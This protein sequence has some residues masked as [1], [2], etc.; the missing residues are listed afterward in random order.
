MHFD[1]TNTNT[2]KDSGACIQLQNIIG[3]P[4]LWVACRKHIG[5]I[6]VG[7]AF[8]ILKVEVN[9]SPDVLVFKRFREDF[10]KIALGTALKKLF[11]INS[12]KPEHQKFFTTQKDIVISTLKEAQKKGAYLRSDYKEL[13]YLV[14][15]Y[16]GEI[17]KYEIHKPGAT[18]RARWLM[19]LLHSI[20][21]VILE[22]NLLAST[23]RK[24]QLKLINRFVLFFVFC[25]VPWW[26]TCPIGTA[27][28]RNDIAFYK[29]VCNYEKIDEDISK[30]LQES[31][32]FHQWCIIPETI[33]LAPFDEGLDRCEKD[34]LAK[35]I[36]SYPQEESKTMHGNGY[37]K[38]RFQKMLLM[39]R[40]P[41][42]F[43]CFL[44]S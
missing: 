5:E 19:K 22:N 2:G 18:H 20:K 30:V 16:L 10:N 39:Q 27:A 42:M 34:N 37:G 41:L 25:Y 33:P 28:A 36:L 32:K 24:G 3:R 26:F 21:I 13:I 12:I 11:D 44:R 17:D 40:T 7:K 15:F 1:T 9:A 43:G 31:F 8:D 29:I 23:L 6:H 35:K 4:L 38:P 14:Y